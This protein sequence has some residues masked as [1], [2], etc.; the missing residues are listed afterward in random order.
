MKQY[1]LIVFII[2][3]ISIV[4]SQT[5]MFDGSS[6]IR[7]SILSVRTE[8]GKQLTGNLALDS[9]ISYLES[10]DGKIAEDTKSL[11]NAKKSAWLAAGLSAV[12][13]GAGELY[14]ER[15]L[16]SIIFFAVEATAVAV[17]ISYNKKGNNQTSF[18]QG[19]ADKNW[20]VV[21]YAS[22]SYNLA[23]Q[24]GLD[25]SKYA[26]LGDPTA[27]TVNWNLLNNLESDLSATSFGQFYSHQLPP[28]G[29]QQYY[30]LIGKYP[31]FNAGWIDFDASKVWTYGDPLTS[32][33]IYYSQQRGKANDYYNVAAKAVVI[34]VLN[35]IISVADAAWST[36]NY[37]KDLEMNVSLERFDRGFETVYYPQLNL[38]FNL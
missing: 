3:G 4:R 9:R 22:W 38:R 37:N 2:V 15:Y 17:G 36:R 13:P 24:N 29:E 20:S 5:V 18:F 7:S 27:T 21:R 33:F 8:S 25:V 28:H 30:E 26:S 1:C 12:V 11:D 31:Q 34:I 23:K 10:V 14:S 6:D 35:H 19:Y 16:K 32:D